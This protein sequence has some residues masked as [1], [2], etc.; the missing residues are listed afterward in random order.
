M[1][2]LRRFQVMTAAGWLGLWALCCAAGAESAPS[3]GTHASPVV[4]ELSAADYE[5]VLERLLPLNCDAPSSPDLTTMWVVTV[6]ASAALGNPPEY[7][8]ELTTKTDGTSNVRFARLE[9]SL[10]VQWEGLRRKDPTT[11]T[12][13]LLR[14]VRVQRFQ[15]TGGEEAPLLRDLVR[16]F[17]D[18]RME[19]ALDSSLVLDPRHYVLCVSA[20]SQELRASLLGGSNGET[21]EPVVRWIERARSS[22]EQAMRHPQSGPASA[23]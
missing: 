16:G 1:R 22:L 8:F 15:L 2:G 9:K 5:S 11:S 6:R 17:E 14:I 4:E 3:T 10:N 19:V 13:D 20:G 21:E 23:P 12:E 18:L 7:R